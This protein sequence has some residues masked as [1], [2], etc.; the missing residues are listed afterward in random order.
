MTEDDD[1]RVE[2]S[3]SVKAQMEADPEKAK[4]LR[5]F[6]EVLVAAQN[7]VREGRYKTFDEAMFA[8][9]GSRPTKI[10]NIEGDDPN[11]NPD[12]QFT[13]EEIIPADDE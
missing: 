2:L 8:L 1:I 9:T 11:D 4:A 5:S 7:G 3:D 6:M 10:A 12:G 13:I